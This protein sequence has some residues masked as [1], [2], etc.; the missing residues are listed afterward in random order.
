MMIMIIN[1]RLADNGDDYTSFLLISKL[2]RQI[3]GFE[4]L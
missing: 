1:I 3:F 4:I 2:L